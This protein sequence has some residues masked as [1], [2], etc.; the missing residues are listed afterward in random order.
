MRVRV[1]AYAF[2]FN[3]VL[4]Q[5]NK[6]P[7][8][9]TFTEWIIYFTMKI[10][11]LH[12]GYHIMTRALQFLPSF[13]SISIESIYVG[14]KERAKRTKN[15]VILSLK[16]DSALSKYQSPFAIRLINPNLVLVHVNV[17]VGYRYG[18]HKST[19]HCEYNKNE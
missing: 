6:N 9:K 12:I 2:G 17:C 10:A 3:H 16:H 7:G 13:S 18:S 8:K 19:K 1:F 11:A 4:S 5:R 15:T 14:Y